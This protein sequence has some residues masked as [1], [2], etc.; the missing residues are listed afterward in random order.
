MQRII[1]KLAVIL[2]VVFSIALSQN[3]DLSSYYP[4]RLGAEWTYTN[5]YL[6][7]TEKIVDTTRINGV[8]YYGLAVWSEQP[9]CWLREDSNKIYI[10]ND[11][12]SSEYLLFDFNA[13]TGT[14]WNLSPDFECF[15]GTKIT[16][17][18]KQDTILT[19]IGMFT[20][21][22]H[23]KHWQT[24]IDAG[25]YDTWFAKGVGKVRY[26]ED[27][28][29]GLMDYYLSEYSIPT[30]IHSDG[31]QLINDTSKLLHNYPNPFNSATTIE[32]VIDQDSPIELSIFDIDG[33]LINVLLKEAQK[34][35]KYSI[36]WFPANRASGIYI[37]Q[38]QTNDIQLHKK[39]VFLK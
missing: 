9:N 36:D 32:Y 24:C 1:K 13:D 31:R 5:D 21:C 26:L 18:G 20:N 15:V 39:V 19:P 33:R 16:L 11:R 2:S 23:F 8:L 4:L 29:A 37:I 6:P 10:L 22:Y 14:Y 3:D 30:S 34:A 12:D 27:N 7:H 28:F 35:G 17:A 25:I 38:L